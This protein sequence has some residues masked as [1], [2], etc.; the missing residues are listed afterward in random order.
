MGGG[1]AG[2]IVKWDFF[3]MYDFSFFRSNLD[4]V[5]ERLAA[6]GFTLDVEAFRA[7]DAGR[8]AAMT[9]TESLQAQRKSESQQIG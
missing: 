1:E 2:A 7:V 6:R 4:A 5:A 8:R 3:D 9:E